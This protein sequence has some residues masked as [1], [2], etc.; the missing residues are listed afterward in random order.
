MKSKY[1]VAVVLSSLLIAGCATGR[2]NQ[3]D[4]D[5]LNA[6]V[7]ALQGQLNAKDQEMAALKNQLD[8]EKMSREAAESALK[9]ADAARRSAEASA[10]KKTVTDFK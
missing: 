10:A 4:L 3:A 8:E 1:W 2:N 7:A 9:S 6:R 5:A